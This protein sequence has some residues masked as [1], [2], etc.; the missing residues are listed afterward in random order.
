MT[1]RPLLQAM[2]GAAALGGCATP[3]PAQRLALDLD[4]GLSGEPSQP[5]WL[6]L[7]VGY[8]RQREPWPLLVFLH[9]S[10]ERGTELAKVRVHGPAKH[11][12]QGTQ[13]YPLIL[14]SPLLAEGQSWQPRRLQ[15][16]LR[17]LQRDWRIDARRV[18]ATGLS[19]GGAGVWDWGCAHPE[20]LAALVPVCGYGDASKVA[21]LR[22]MPIRAYHGDADSVV[23]L[24]RQQ[25]LV[26]AVR[27]AGGRPEFI[28]YPGVDHNAWDPAYQDPALLPWLLSQARP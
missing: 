14:A 27:A 5:L 4:L 25:L 18:Y 6:D 19:R 24:A 12:D 21:V 2:L 22:D 20:T 3:Q 11:I 7:P 9:G 1:R 10:G 8:A 23:P 17:A 16:M 26:D 13:R 28:V 15:A